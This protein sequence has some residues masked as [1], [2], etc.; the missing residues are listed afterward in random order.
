MLF[1]SGELWA[2]RKWGHRL[3]RCHDLYRG[4]GFGALNAQRVSIVIR[5]VPQDHRNRV[6]LVDRF[7]KKVCYSVLKLSAKS[8]EE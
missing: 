2:V 5:D 3:Y 1:Y 7:E 6:S 4:E 8:T